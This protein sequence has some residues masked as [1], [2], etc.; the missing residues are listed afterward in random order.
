MGT[1]SVPVTIVN[2]M[3]P[4]R[5]VTLEC[6]VDTGATC[7]IIPAPVLEQLGIRL[8]REDTFTVAT[9]EQRTWTMGGVQLQVNGRTGWSMAVLGPVATPP[10]IGSHGLEALGLGVDPMRRRLIP[11]TPLAL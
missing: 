4:T 8:L 11:I 10:V 6:L 1:F 2:P 3:D 7:S 5:H 9:G